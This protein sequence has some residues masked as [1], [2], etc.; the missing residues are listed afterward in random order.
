MSAKSVVVALVCLIGTVSIGSAQG[1]QT[2]TIRG[3]VSDEQGLPMPAAT[4][5]IN[6][7]ALQASR[8]FI[9]GDDGRYV[10]RTLP[11]GDYEVVV[12]R[13]S[14]ARALT[15][16]AVLLGL[17]TEQNITLKVSGGRE[18]IDVVAETPAPAATAIVGLNIR[19]NEVDALPL[20]RTLAGIAELS[21][22]LTSIT[23]NK[24]QVSIGG[25]TA[26]DSL[27]MVNGVDVND[28]VLGSPQPLFVEDAIQEVQ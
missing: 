22:A 14:F 12:Q 24:D 25:A 4:V 17:D 18:A 16:S 1:V 5:T 11:P 3:L 27:F 8:S 19:H 13:P 9:T 10:F 15:K 28:N 7:P 21:P 2:G 26:F 23:P 6:S 20:S